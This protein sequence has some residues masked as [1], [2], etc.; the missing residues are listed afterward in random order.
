VPDETALRLIAEQL[1]RHDIDHT[2]IIERDPPWHGAAM[3]IGLAPVS[4]RSV[5]R[6]VLGRLSLLR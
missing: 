3:A 4:D 5:V 2:L 1:V 6:R